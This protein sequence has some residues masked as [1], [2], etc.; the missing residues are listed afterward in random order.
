MTFQGNNFGQAFLN[1]KKT[2]SIPVTISIRRDGRIQDIVVGHLEHGEVCDYMNDK[3]EQVTEPRWVARSRV[4]NDSFE[5][6]TQ[7]AAKHWLEIVGYV[8]A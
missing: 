2:V 1:R 5:F 8:H 3:G 7:G 6:A 4:K